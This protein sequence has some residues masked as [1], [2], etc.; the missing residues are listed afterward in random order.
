[1]TADQAPAPDNVTFHNHHPGDG[2]SREELLKGLMAEE[3]W[4][5]PKFF[6]DARG[7]ELFEQITGQPEYY[8]TRTEKDI[9]ARYAGEMHAACGND[10][11]LIEPGSGSSDKVRLLLDDLQPAAYV[12]LDISADFLLQSARRLG[13]DFPWLQ[14]FAICADFS[15]KWQEPDELPAGRRVVFYPGSTIGNLEPADARDFLGHVRTWIGEDGGA[16]VGVDMHKDDAT[17]NAAYNDAEGVTAAFNRNLLRHVNT[18]L[19]ADFSPDRFHHRAFYNREARRIEMHLVAAGEQRVDLGGPVIEFADGESIHT[20]NS[21]K[22]SPGDFAAL[23]GAAGLRV[24]ERWSDED[25]LF[26]IFYLTPA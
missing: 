25:E 13:R 23:C 6:Y 26:S 8:P 3:K 2:N 9:L 21:Y 18:V 11:V 24:Q 10:C 19:E 14:I 16:L 15:R 7:S 20:E 17:L 4:I 1:M 22:Y 12:P 5:S